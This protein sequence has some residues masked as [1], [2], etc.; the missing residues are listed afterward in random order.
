MQMSSSTLF[1]FVEGFS[2]RY[3]YSRVV[4]DT[5]ASRNIKYEIVTAEELPGQAGGKT[6]LLSFFDYAKRA[7]LLRNDLQGKR[8]VSLFFL[9][10]D[11]DDIF[12]RRRRSSHVV[13]TR[14]YDIEGT[15][16]RFADVARAAAGASCLDL[17]STRVAL[18]SSS[19]WC[20]KAASAWI[21]W[22][23]LCLVACTCAPKA[24][25]YYS[26]PVSQIHPGPYSPID[27]AELAKH[28]S[29][30][31]AAS[32][33]SAAKFKLVCD[34]IDRLVSKAFAEGAYDRFFRGK[35]YP[36]LLRADVQRIAAGRRCNLSNFADRVIS[37][38]AENAD[39]NSA[40][41]QPYRAAVVGL[42]S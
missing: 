5:C 37:C 9:D 36:A 35:W 38:L 8:T 29:A 33:L 2:D 40:W 25:S 22:V 13:Y 14:T 41:T 17:N 19:L 26:R 21:E 20:R 24:G 12:R 30:L 42:L 23:K 15:L 1:G 4:D 31:A 39:Y 28:R 3:I 32:G 27:Q 11:V 7:T 6:A 16:F 34:K 10:K 18:G